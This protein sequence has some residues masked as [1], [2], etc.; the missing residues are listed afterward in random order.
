M[1]KIEESKLLAEEQKA[2]YLMQL[3]ML[4][5]DL[6]VQLNSVNS[7]LRTIEQERV[8]VANLASEMN[9]Q[10]L[11]FDTQLSDISATHALMG[12]VEKNN[13]KLKVKLTGLIKTRNDLKVTYS[14][15]DQK[16]DELTLKIEIVDRKIFDA[17]AETERI[18][19]DIFS[20]KA[21]MTKRERERLEA[22][23]AKKISDAKKKKRN[24]TLLGAAVAVGGIIIYNKTQ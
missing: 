2:E 24:R 22:L 4:V 12:P 11:R 17:N 8:D 9:I 20:T 19:K 5:S 18:D 21:M 13:E 15:L 23:E 14:G 7:R 1:Q 3:N 10:R 6:D 16:R